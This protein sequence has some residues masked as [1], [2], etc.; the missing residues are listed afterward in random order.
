VRE[1]AVLAATGA[2]VFAQ[3]QP[4]GVKSLHRAAAVVGAGRVLGM[5][6]VD[7]WLIARL[8]D[9]STTSPTTLGIER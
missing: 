8:V 7:L 5:Y 2:L 4:A 6:Y 1:H 3:R 9:A